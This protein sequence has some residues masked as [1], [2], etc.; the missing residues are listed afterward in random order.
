M[1]VIN[2][3][4]KQGYQDCKEGRPYYPHYILEFFGKRSRVTRLTN[5]ERA[6][7]VKGWDAAIMGDAL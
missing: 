7:Y 1:L 4:Y 6:E 5:S 2:N 3:P